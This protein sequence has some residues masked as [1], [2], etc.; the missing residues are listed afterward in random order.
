MVSLGYGLI[1]VVAALA[2]TVGLLTTTRGKGGGI[3]LARLASEIT[4]ASVIKIMVDDLK[5]IECDVP[6]CPLA[7]MCKLRNVIGEGRSAF[8]DTL[9]NYTIADLIDNRKPLRAAGWL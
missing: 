3:P 4:V 9:E 5:I 8:L 1:F 2:L 7:S 6:K